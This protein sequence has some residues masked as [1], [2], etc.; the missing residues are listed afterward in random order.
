MNPVGFGERLTLLRTLAGFRRQAE[1]ARACGVTPTTINRAEKATKRTGDK[2]L[3]AIVATLH[4]HV[5]FDEA[6]LVYGVGEPPNSAPP[7][8]VL[9][10]LGASSL[11]VGMS[12][13]VRGALLK[14]P[15]AALCVANPS[16]EQIA[17]VRMMIES[18]LTIGAQ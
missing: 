2:A 4:K 1:F 8:S 9:N 12:D 17:L 18:N 14:F 7:A 15:W 16:T 13:E 3:T 10:Y 11:A 6:W 5:A